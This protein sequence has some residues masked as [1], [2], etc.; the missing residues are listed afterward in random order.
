MVKRIVTLLLVVLL[1]AAVLPG[2][3]AYGKDRGGGPRPVIFVHGYS[4]SGA[5]FATQAKR[6]TANGYPADRI[7]THEYDSQ[8]LHT[9]EA[10]VYAALDGR[11]TRLLQ[12]TGADRVDLLA[13]SLGTRL[14][15]TYLRSSPERAARVAHYVNLD[16]STSADQPGGVPTLAVWGE[17]DPARTVG[18]ARNVHFPDQSHTQTVTSPQTFTE[19]YGF[20]TGKAPRTTEI[21]PQP[22]V[23]LAGRA[24]LFPS[25]EGAAGARLEIFRVDPRTGRR[26]GHHP[27][28]AY[29]IG[30]DGSWG[31]FRGSGTAHYEFALIWNEEQTHHLYLPP[32]RRSDH[33]IRLLTSHPGE[34]VS[35][36]VET[37]D[38]HTALSITRNKEWWGDQGEAGDSLRV[39]GQEIVNAADAPRTKRTIGIFAQDAGS[40]GVTDLT[41]PLPAFHALP[42]LTGVDLYLPAA[43][44]RSH[45]LTA[46]PRATDGRPDTLNVPAWPSSTDRVSVQFDDY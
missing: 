18:G 8:F 29:D 4:G 10:D 11:I 39:D 15:Q 26:L 31:P 33:L 42:F 35:A 22:R 36:L 14:M 43:P 23:T 2:S 20:F 24:Q 30:A 17:G 16:G 25:N 6:L 44:G 45:T 28:A 38:R 1:G 5:Q 27:V 21:K 3:G 40:D 32:S 34:G 13:H 41:A 19:F 46:L 37:S 7:E 12:R 9:T